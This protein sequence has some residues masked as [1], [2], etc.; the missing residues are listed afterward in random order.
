MMRYCLLIPFGMMAALVPS[1]AGKEVIFAP[2][3]KLKIEAGK[4]AGGEGPAW[5]PKLGVLTSGNGHIYRLDRSGRSRIY[6]KNAGTN[7]LLFDSKGRLLACEP[8]F[9]RITRTDID[10]TITVLT[11]RYQGNR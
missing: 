8:V 9:H 7:G 2:H 1:A 4:G 5:D 10:G 6:R 3:A 11:D